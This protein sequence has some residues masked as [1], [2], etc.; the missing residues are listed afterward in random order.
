LPECVELLLEHG[1]DPE[2]MDGEG[3]CDTA[4]GLRRRDLVPASARSLTP[5]CP[6]I[7]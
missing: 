7:L 3:R 2:A 1:A 5:L 6:L 4:R